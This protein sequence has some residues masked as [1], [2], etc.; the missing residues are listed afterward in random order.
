MA[1]WLQKHK[2][3]DAKKVTVFTLAE[4]IA[5][6]A[7]VTVVEQP[8]GIASTMG[9]GYVNKGQDIR[10]L[11]AEGVSFASGAT[12]DAE[13]KIIFPD[14]VA[15][16]FLRGLLHQRQRGLRRHR[17]ADAQPALPQRVRRG[18]LRRR[19]RAQARRHRPPAV[20]DRGP[21][22]RQEPRAAPAPAQAD[23]P[24]A[25]IVLCIGDM[26]A[27]KAFYIHSNT[28]YGGDAA[29]LGMG[30]IPTC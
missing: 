25:P 20:R 19:H 14:W 11:T 3:G 5:E 10:R 21:A 23:A 6:D 26:G 2:L 16:D 1:T 17:P 22:D 7:G 18:R 24:L 29:V 13:L 30:R 4:M 27:G 8:L 28:W 12:I 15:H 9:F